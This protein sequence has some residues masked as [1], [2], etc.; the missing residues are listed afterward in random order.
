VAVTLPQAGASNQ[1]VNGCNISLLNIGAGVATVT[2]TTSTING[3]ATLSL[4]GK[5]GASI[6]SD[7][8]NYTASV[9]P[10]LP[11][12]SSTVTANCLT[13]ADSSGVVVIGTTVLDGTNGIKGPLIACVGAPGNTTGPYG[14]LCEVRATGAL[15]ACSNAAG[16]TLAADWAAAG[17][18]Q[19]YPGAGIPVS[20]GSAWTTSKT[21]PSGA[22]VG[23]TDTQALTNKTVDGVTPTTFG[24]L[25]PTSSV[26]TQLNA[27]VTSGGALGTPSSGTGTNIAGIP[28]ANILNR[29]EYDAGTCTTTATID[30]ANGPFQ[31]LLLGGNCTVTWTQPGAGV[32]RLQLVITQ[33]ASAYTVTWNSTLWP[34]GIAPVISTANAA[35][36][37]IACYLNGTTTKCTAAQN[38]Q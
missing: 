7:G 32:T 29:T 21:A 17:G 15:W 6:V 24:Y 38:F 33:G 25:D 3:G 13:N 30:A 8:S 5:Q 10:G 19:V 37:A 9:S 34:S 14:S 22:I 26:Q 16:C 12:C 11:L 28:A 31:K 2:P 4:A 35:V 20:T 23:D 18:S 36:D 27:K 1:F